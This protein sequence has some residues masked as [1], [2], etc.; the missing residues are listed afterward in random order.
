MEL[1]SDTVTEREFEPE[2][3]ELDRYF[4]TKITLNTIQYNIGNNTIN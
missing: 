3:L 4:V 2:L 1:A